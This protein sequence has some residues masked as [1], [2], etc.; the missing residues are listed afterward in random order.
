MNKIEMNEAK[1]VLG[2]AFVDD[3]LGLIVLSVV[4]AVA[5]RGAVEAGQLSLILLKTIL[6]A[7]T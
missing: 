7:A 5:T 3:V 2:A 6:Y 1:T 4:T